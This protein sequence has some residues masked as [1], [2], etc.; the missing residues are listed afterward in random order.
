MQNQAFLNPGPV[1]FAKNVV[2]AEIPVD[3][4]GYDTL[5]NSGS[6]VLASTTVL[7]GLAA[8][9]YTLN[10]VIDGAAAADENVVIGALSPTIADLCAAIDAIA[11]VTCTFDAVNHVIKITSDTTGR[12][13]NVTVIDG[14]GGTPLIAAINA[15]A[16]PNITIAVGPAVAG[17]EGGF[18]FQVIDVPPTDMDFMY[19]M[20]VRT[21]ATGAEKVGFTTTYNKTTGIL[22]IQ[23]EAS[24]LANGDVVKVIG[25]FGVVS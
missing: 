1:M 5:I 4:A 19:I 16:L 20:E 21:I 15:L 14:V 18:N 22:A 7:T 12:L 3:S 25:T 2:T 8:D 13:S 23:D 9:T 24:S 10:M 6:A 11:G 17:I